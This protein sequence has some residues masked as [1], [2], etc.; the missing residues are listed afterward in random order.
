[1]GLNTT[2]W[3]EP[4]D[5]VSSKESRKQMLETK[6]VAASGHLAVKFGG[7]LGWALKAPGK[8]AVSCLLQ[9]WMSNVAL[10][11]IRCTIP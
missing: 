5:P 10:N 4:H 6:L 3:K 9:G 7:T 11:L 2:T 1:M 8:S